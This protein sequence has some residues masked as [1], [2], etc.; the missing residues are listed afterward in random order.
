MP[1]TVDWRVSAR[2]LAALQADA[3][4]LHAQ[5]QASSAAYLETLARRMADAMT[6]DERSLHEA[7]DPAGPTPRLV[8]PFAHTVFV[9]TTPHC[10]SACLDFVDLLKA[11]PGTERVGLET[12]S[13]TDYLELAEAK[14]PSGQANLR[15]AMKVYRQRKRGANVSY[16]PTVVWDEGVMNDASI[17]RWIDQL[18]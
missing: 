17:V 4:A 7:S 2:N 15:Y 9:L 10:A 16:Q 6:H 8:S 12:S 1:T 14:L 18:R 3:A 5:A 11:L 13:D